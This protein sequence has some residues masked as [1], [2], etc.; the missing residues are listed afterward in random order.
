VFVC[1]SC[2]VYVICIASR[3]FCS[4]HGVGFDGI[5]F[6]HVVSG[7]LKK[8]DVSVSCYVHLAL[9]AYISPYFSTLY[10]NISIHNNTNSHAT[11]SICN[12][13]DMRLARDCI[14]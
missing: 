4:G 7:K 13:I 14:R 11:N 10:D 3:C 9:S 1:P 2:V 12:R 5:A 6:N 8:T